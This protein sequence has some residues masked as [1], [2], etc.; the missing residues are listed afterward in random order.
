MENKTE[1]ME[2]NTPE[3]RVLFMG[4]AGTGL[5][6]GTNERGENL[7]ITI[8]DTPDGRVMEIGTYQNN[9]WLIVREYGSYGHCQDDTVM[10]RWDKA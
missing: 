2:L 1:T 5:F 9:G 4:K 7:I 10:G 8:N 3:Q 6:T